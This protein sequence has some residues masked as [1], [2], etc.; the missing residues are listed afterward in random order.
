MIKLSTIPCPNY[1][2]NH[3]PSVTASALAHLALVF[4]A[5]MTISREKSFVVGGNSGAPCKNLGRDEDNFMTG[6]AIVLNPC[7]YGERV[8]INRG[9]NVMFHK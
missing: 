5:C 3:F 1:G 2:G 7:H 4:S 8:F 6:M 9:I